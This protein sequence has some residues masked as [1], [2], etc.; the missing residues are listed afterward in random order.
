MESKT[1]TPGD[2]C[3]YCGREVSLEDTK[4]IYGRSYGLAYICKGYPF[5][6]DAFVGVHKGTE[7]PKGRLANEEL[8]RYKKLAHTYFDRQ[9]RGLDRKA[10]RDSYKW[11]GRELGIDGKHCHI[12][13][14]DIDL[15]KR[16]IELCQA[17]NENK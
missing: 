9:W 17:K 16:T 1:H 3:P 5:E 2:P 13:W 11:L 14:F 8:R 6:C 10:R 12:G 7:I 4:T 15:C